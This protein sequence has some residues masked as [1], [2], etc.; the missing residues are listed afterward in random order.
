MR[1]NQFDMAT[2]ILKERLNDAF[3]LI[4]EEAH[5]TDPYRMERVPRKELVRLY[6]NLDE[7]GLN[8]LI[9]RYGEDQVNAFLRDM[10]AKDGN[11]GSTT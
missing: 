10:M 2:D 9:L 11:Y 7:D 4:K 3:A 8:S 6:N 5:G 1:K